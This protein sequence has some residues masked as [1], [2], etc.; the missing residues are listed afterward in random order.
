MEKI[1][2]KAEFYGWSVEFDADNGVY[3]AT[4]DEDKVEDTNFKSLQQR[5]R[6]YSK[7]KISAIYDEEKVTCHFVEGES[8]LWITKNNG[9]R[10]KCYA[11]NV[12]VD[13]EENNEIVKE[14]IKLTEKE[15]RA[16]G[17][18]LKN[19]DTR[20][21]ADESGGKHKIIRRKS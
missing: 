12:H 11:D 8:Q 20:K 9:S 14:I 4:K 5:L 3:T 18:A 19:R 2:F 7:E 6:T 17:C 10:E 16:F 13:N 21:T 1:K 15:K